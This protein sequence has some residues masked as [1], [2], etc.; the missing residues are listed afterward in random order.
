MPDVLGIRFKSCGKI[1]DFET[2]GIEAK[3]G[4]FV[5]VESDFGLSLGKVIKESRSIEKSER[6]LKR[7]VRT[8]SE[9]DFRAREDNKQL[10][11]D[12]RVFCVER[13]MA[14][15]L[16][17]KLVGTETTLD[18]KRIVFYFTA[19]GRIDFRELVK[20]LASR[21][22]TRIEMRQIGVRDEAKLV[23]GFGVCGRPICCKTFLTAFDPVS[24]KMAKKQEMVLNIGKLSGL[25]SRL[26]CCLRYEYD[27]D[28]AAIST[29][30]DI[31]IQLDT[32]VKTGAPVAIT[33]K[34]PEPRAEEI[35]EEEDEDSPADE[36][37]KSHVS[38]EAP[39]AG[40]APAPQNQAQAGV[41]NKEGENRKR[42]RRRFKRRRFKKNEPPK[43][44]GP[45]EK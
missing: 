7:V 45:N 35:D 20:D 16:P 17:M 40:S 19:E 34:K 11:K 44:A 24:I 36:A 25:C 38:E 4:D 43:E 23:G 3:E 28:L 10:E 6:E 31:A 41:Q 5:V 9:E 21:F 37:E 1:Y 15:G 27:G 32:T 8:A 26:M 13:I 2:N 22:K 14:R 18:R 39:V 33:E 12:A 42:S 29:D 30:E